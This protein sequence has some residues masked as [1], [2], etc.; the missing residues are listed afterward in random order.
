MES[1]ILF[2]YADK[3]TQIKTCT[4]QGWLHHEF[5]QMGQVGLLLSI[6]ASKGKLRAFAVKEAAQSI[7]SERS[8]HK[9]HSSFS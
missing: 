5:L 7:C 1:N 6:V 9:H 8:K 3:Q 4:Q 2:Q